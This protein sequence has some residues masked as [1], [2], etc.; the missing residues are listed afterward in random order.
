[1]AEHIKNKRKCWQRWSAG[2]CW[3]RVLKHGNLWVSAD[4]HSVFMS[5][6]GYLS[7]L[8]FEPTGCIR[9][10][11]WS[12]KLICSVFPLVF[13]CSWCKSA[14]MMH[15]GLSQDHYQGW[16]SFFLKYHSLAFQEKRA[17]KSLRLNLLIAI[18][19][20]VQ[21]ENQLRILYFIDFLCY[22][23]SFV[24][25]AQTFQH[26]IARITG[27]INYIWAVQFHGISSSITVISYTVFF[28]FFSYNISKCL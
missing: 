17:A 12:M 22:R 8:I 4:I 26:S 6:L 19:C 11:N 7:G 21:D 3:C 24:F 16:M 2:M 23:P 10:G 15:S 20:F 1:M 25:M 14:L 18:F 5:P 9:D 28:C 27:V 13:E